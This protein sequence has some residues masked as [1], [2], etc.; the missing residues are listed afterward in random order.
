M[1][2][3]AE[4]VRHYTVVLYRGLG[5]VRHV[6]QRLFNWG[7]TVTVAGGNYSGCGGAGG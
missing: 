6:L 2:R 3:E 4:G 7:S 5:R 1:G